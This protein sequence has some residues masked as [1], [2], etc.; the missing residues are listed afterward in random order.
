MLKVK[1]LFRFILLI[2]D[3]VTHK[4]FA[5]QKNLGPI[6]ETLQSKNFNILVKDIDINIRNAINHGGVV[7]KVA[8]G[9][10]NIIEFIYD[11]KRQSTVLPLNVNAFDNLI[12]N[13]YDT[14]SGV[15][16]PYLK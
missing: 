2:I 1:N 15:L 4:D 7:F 3:Q 12:N 14:A 9:S 8:E 5:S 16:L 11:E 13:V 10:T 6:C